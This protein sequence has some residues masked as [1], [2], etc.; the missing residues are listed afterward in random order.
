METVGKVGLHGSVGGEKGPPDLKVTTQ[1]FN[2][3]AEDEI[4]RLNLVFN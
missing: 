4:H 2:P 3:L 1:S